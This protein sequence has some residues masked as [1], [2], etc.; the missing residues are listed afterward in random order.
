M[1]IGSYLLDENGNIVKNLY[2]WDVNQKLIIEA[3]NIATAPKIHFCNKN[4]EQALVV[5][6][7]ISD[8][9]IVAN[10]PNILLRE[11]Y[12]ILAYVYLENNDSGKTVKVIEIKLRKRVKPDDYEYVDNVEAIYLTDLIRLVET[13]NTNMKSA[14]SLR[15]S[16]TTQAINNL[17]AVKEQILQDKENGLFNGEKGDVGKS[18]YESALEGGYTG[19]EAEFYSALATLNDMATDE[20]ANDYLFGTV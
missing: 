14:E 5:S 1:M 13:L 20:E 8:N 7:T 3:Y 10:I 12:N 9:K 18:A 6:S 17:N 16:N 15:E 4:S 11:P 19:T 2:Q